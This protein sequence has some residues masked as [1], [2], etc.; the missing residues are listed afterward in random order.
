MNFNQY[1]LGSALYIKVHVKEL[2]REQQRSKLYLPL[3]FPSGMTKGT[4]M[5]GHC[6]L[7]YGSLLTSTKLLNLLGGSASILSEGIGSSMTVSWPSDDRVERAI[8]IFSSWLKAE[9]LPVVDHKIK[10]HSKGWLTARNYLNEVARHSINP[11]NIYLLQELSSFKNTSLCH[12]ISL[13]TLS[14]DL[15][16]YRLLDCAPLNTLCVVCKADK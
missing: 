15:Q 12:V 4:V 2:M 9:K 6:S 16:A 10:V 8:S 13:W 7:L 14:Q 5:F 11:S 3:K 1:S